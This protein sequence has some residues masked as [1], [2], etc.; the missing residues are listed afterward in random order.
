MEPIEIGQRRD[1]GLDPLVGR[2]QDLASQVEQGTPSFLG[3]ALGLLV[4]R[5]CHL[6]GLDQA[7]EFRLERIVILPVREV[8]DVILP[9]LLGHILLFAHYNGIDL[10]PSVERKWL[11]RP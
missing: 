4:R 6:E 9:D 7:S 3:L 10:V 5:C 8:G 11:F 2:A 1:G